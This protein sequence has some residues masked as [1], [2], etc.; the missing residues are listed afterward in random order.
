MSHDDA[1]RLA[2]AK[3]AQ[4][5]RISVCLPAR[6]EELTV[7]HIVASVRHN[8]VERS[9]LVDE[10]LVLDDDSTDATA[11]AARWAGAEVHAVEDVLAELGRGSGKGNALWKSLYVAEGDLVVWCDA[12]VLNF[13]PHFVTRLVAPLLE[14]PAIGFTKGFYRRPLHQEPV[15]GGRVTELLA[16]PLLC[17]LFPHL[18]DL[19]QPLS[20]E[21]AGRRSLLEQ[22]P[23][24]MGYGVELGLL[25][26]LSERFGLDVLR[27]ADLGVRSHRNR[28]LEELAPQ[29]MAILLTG[30]RRAGIPA[31]Q[32]SSTLVRFGEGEHRELLQVET[33]ERPPMITVPEYR[34]KFNRELSA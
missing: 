21:Y 34:T 32:L 26:D 29:A 22:L 5:L 28:P 25:V 11:D 1:E 7:G 14:E 8:L 23:F 4:G 17:A 9:G 27:Q 18:S 2:H 30:L 15:G 31:S 12:D 10:I 16:R 33:R 19:V 3:Q 20:G 24:V 13:A 6:N